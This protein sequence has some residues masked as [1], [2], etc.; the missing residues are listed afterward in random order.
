MPRLKLRCPCGDLIH[1]DLFY[2]LPCIWC[3]CNLFAQLYSIAMCKQKGCGISARAAYFTFI[4]DTTECRNLAIIICACFPRMICRMYIVYHTDTICKP[5]FYS[6]HCCWRIPCFSSS[7]CCVAL[8]TPYT[9]SR[10]SNSSI[11][12]RAASRDTG[13]GLG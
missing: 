12:T 5:V 9:E 1:V 7:C 3:F 10:Y 11:R 6:P 2:F 13:A 8:I 4:Y